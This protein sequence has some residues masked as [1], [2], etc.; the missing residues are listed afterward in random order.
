MVEPAEEQEVPEI[1]DAVLSESAEE[2][3]DENYRWTELLKPAAN[4]KSCK[5]FEFPNPT[6]KASTKGL[7][8]LRA[9]YFNKQMSFWNFTFGS[10]TSEM[11]TFDYPMTHSELMKYKK[12][13]QYLKV[14]TM[15]RSH[16][17][18]KLAGI[19]CYADN[20]R[21]L[22]SSGWFQGADCQVFELKPGEKVVG[23]KGFYHPSH[24]A[25][26]YDVQFLI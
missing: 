15:P 24:P 19:R 4:H 1:A 16:Y 9:A 14:F 5:R 7:T 8:D 23:V 13:I 26:L 20:D 22:L 21:N 10:L 3:E 6:Q 11:N 12:G 17:G 2:S 25:I 18:L